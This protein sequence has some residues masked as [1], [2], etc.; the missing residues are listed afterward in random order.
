MDLAPRR[1]HL[2]ECRRLD[3][4]LSQTRLGTFR[5]LESER[6]LI[7]ARSSPC[8]RA[9]ERV[10]VRYGPFERSAPEHFSARS[11]LPARSGLFDPATNSLLHNHLRA[12][13]GHPIALT[14][15]ICRPEK[16]VPH[17]RAIHGAPAPRPL[18]PIQPR[19]L[20]LA[21]Q[22][23]PHFLPTKGYSTPLPYRARR[24][25]CGACAAAP[26]TRTIRSTSPSGKDQRNV[27]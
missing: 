24:T 10:D 26:P 12:A 19:P 16:T 25:P 8:G 9:V 18:T 6:V 15:A 20:S 3:V 11:R 14:I 17:I 7:R 5:S 22:E 1:Q 21:N 4:G 23:C 27:S 13:G 2:A